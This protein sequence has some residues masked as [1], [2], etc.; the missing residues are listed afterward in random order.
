VSDEQ[1]LEAA[2]AIRPFLAELVG[3]DADRVDRELAALL[4]RS[5]DDED[6]D[7]ER[8]IL[9]CL[10]RSPATHDWAAR[11]LT[12]QGRDGAGGRQRGYSPVG[13]DGE[14]VAAPRF[15]CPEGDTV[16]YRHS[17]GQQPPICTTHGLALQP[18]PGT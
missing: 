6:G 18:D 10:M 2:R 9:G 16:W 1:V 12:D 5:H 3:S 4:A 7:V 8:L 17:V 11:F 13:G 14:P 15:A